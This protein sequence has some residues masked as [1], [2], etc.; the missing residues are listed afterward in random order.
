MAYGLGCLSVLST[1]G[2]TGVHASGDIDHYLVGSRACQVSRVVEG[3]I[4]VLQCGD[5]Q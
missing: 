1:V 5:C 2:H 4:P 3:R